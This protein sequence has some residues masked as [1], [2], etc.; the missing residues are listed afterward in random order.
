MPYQKTN[1]YHQKLLRLKVPDLQE[2][3]IRQVSVIPQEKMIE[4]NMRR[5]MEDIDEKEV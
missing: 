3:G 1:R 4:G 2:E 5:Y